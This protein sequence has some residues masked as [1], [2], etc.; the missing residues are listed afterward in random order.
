MRLILQ[1]KHNV[2]SFF[3]KNFQ[4][5]Y[6]FCQK[7]QNSYFFCKIDENFIKLTFFLQ[8]KRRLSHIKNYYAHFTK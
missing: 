2:F 7:E 4:A 6:S 3:Y 5:V 8:K 1:K